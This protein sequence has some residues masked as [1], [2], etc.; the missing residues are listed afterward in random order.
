MSESH[1]VTTYVCRECKSTDI[2]HTANA[3]HDP[4]TDTFVCHDVHDEHWCRNCEAEKCADYRAVS[5]D[6]PKPEPVEVST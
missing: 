3:T 2:G 5:I 4:Y 1:I 6:G